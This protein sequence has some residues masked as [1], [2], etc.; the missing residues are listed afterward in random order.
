MPDGDVA[1][2]VRELRRRQH[3]Q[4]NQMQRIEGQQLADRMVSEERHR[5]VETINKD[6]K[7]DLTNLS[8]IVTAQNDSLAKINEGQRSILQ[9]MESDRQ[10]RIETAAALEAAEK[11]RRD[12][13]A[14]PW[15][16]PTRVFAFG[17]GFLGLAAYL[18]HGFQ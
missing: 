5:Q 6:I 2:W 11:A 12:K 3:S 14:E 1:E 18:T 8:H 15:V 13:G 7:A 9:T 4:G 17:S 16:T 10:T